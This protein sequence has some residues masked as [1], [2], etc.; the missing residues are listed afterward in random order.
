MGVWDLFKYPGGRSLLNKLLRD[1][2]VCRTA[3]AT[4]GTCITSAPGFIM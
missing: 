4:Q 1:N 3:S 2:L